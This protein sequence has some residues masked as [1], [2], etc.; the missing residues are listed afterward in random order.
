MGTVPSGVCE[1]I[2]RPPD[3][4]AVALD[5]DAGDGVGAGVGLVEGM[6]QVK[7]RVVGLAGGGLV[8]RSRRRS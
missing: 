8:G 4:G 1:G 6:D 5:V 7:G 3:G 2:R